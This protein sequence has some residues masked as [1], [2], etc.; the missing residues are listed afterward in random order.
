VVAE[1]GELPAEIGVEDRVTF[2][3]GDMFE[4]VPAADGYVMKHVLHDWEDDECVEILENIRRA[5]SPG[6][7]VLVAEWVIPGP[8]TPHPSKV[9]D[10]HMMVAEGGRERTLEEYGEVFE[11]AGLELSAHHEPGGPRISVVEGRV[12]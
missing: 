1:A 4:E 2:T 6:A 10:I 8:D 12:A 11:A 5:A 9:F 7:P 3:A